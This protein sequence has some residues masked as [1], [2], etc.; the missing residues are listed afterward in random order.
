MVVAGSCSGASCPSAE[1]KAN[2]VG[3]RLIAHLLELV[4][5]SEKRQGPPKRL[6][7]VA[8]SAGRAG[9]YQHSGCRFSSSSQY[10][11]YPIT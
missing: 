10:A 7:I 2:A 11:K 8:T 6:Q 1:A 9:V 4:V 5:A 3:M